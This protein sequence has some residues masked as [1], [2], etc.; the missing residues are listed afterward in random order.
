VK[1]NHLQVVI[2]VVVEV[3]AEVKHLSLATYA[4]R[5]NVDNSLVD[6]VAK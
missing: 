1:V 4:F 6:V 2:V 5:K 3:E